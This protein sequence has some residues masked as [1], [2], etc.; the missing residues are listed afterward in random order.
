MD[1]L[2]NSLI[3]SSNHHL[4]DSTTYQLTLHLPTSHTSPLSEAVINLVT[5]S[6]TNERAHQLTHSLTYSFNQLISSP[7]HSPNPS[8]RASTGALFHPAG[9]FTRQPFSSSV[10]NTC[11]EGP[12][13]RSRR[14]LAS[15]CDCVRR[16]HIYLFLRPRLASSSSLLHPLP[17][18]PLLQ[19]LPLPLLVIHPHLLCSSSFHTS[20]PLRKL[21]STATFDDSYLRSLWTI[22]IFRHSFL[23][24]L[25]AIP[26]FDCALNTPL[27][28]PHPPHTSEIPLTNKHFNSPRN[29]IRQ[30]SWKPKLLTTAAL[31]WPSRRSQ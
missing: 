12:H 6:R 27:R 22:P 5:T 31:L 15:T 13:V 23:R 20:I 30:P 29:N 8:F 28:H 7:P 24:H 25:S 16:G 9:S 4:T 3:I 2:R 1:S 26:L 14:C 18:L 11:K 19:L 21:P 17:H 10:P